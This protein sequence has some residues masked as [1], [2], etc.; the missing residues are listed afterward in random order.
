[1]WT[2]RCYAQPVP[3]CTLSW[4]LLV[5]CKLAQP[6]LS[7]RWTIH[8]PVG[9]WSLAQP[10]PSS[11][12]VVLPNGSCILAG[13]FPK[14]PCHTSQLWFHG[15]WWLL[16]AAWLTRHYPQLFVNAEV[17]QKQTH[18]CPQICFCSSGCCGPPFAPAFTGRYYNLAPTGIPFQPQL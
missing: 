12:A 16:Q 5:C 9:C 11:L 18:K 7:P 13:D 1:M 4:L 14:L 8:M 15:C 10:A 17:P 3:A 2:G 6:N